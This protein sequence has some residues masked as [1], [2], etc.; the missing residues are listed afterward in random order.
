VTRPCHLLPDAT[1]RT[2]RAARRFAGILLLLCAGFLPLS[3]MTA[4]A[5]SDAGETLG[6]G[7]LIRVVVFQRPE[8]TT[9]ARISAQG[10]LVVPLVG[11]V[12][13]VGRTPTQAGAAIA[14]RLR[15]GQ[16][17]IRPQ[18]SV[19]LVEVRSRRVSVLGYVARPGSFGLDGTTL[20]LSDALAQA[21]GIDKDGSDTVIV[22]TRRNGRSEKLEIDVPAIYLTGNLSHD[23][24]LASG[25]TVF[26]PSAPVFYIYGAVQRPGEYRLQ[27]HTSVRN[28][29]TLGGGLSPRGTERRVDIHRRM[30]DGTVKPHDAELSDPVE[31]DDI[32]K[33]GE[34]IF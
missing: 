9:E 4:G 16:F 7:D 17:V 5:A 21:G 19:N 34:S 22:M 11:E 8:L 10:T 27:A 12:P 6:P 1:H 30:P 24:E 2:R 26:V 25:D 23:V 14:E 20:T 28:A 29:I 13:V 32:I 31:P 33:V 3:G 15:K 18:V